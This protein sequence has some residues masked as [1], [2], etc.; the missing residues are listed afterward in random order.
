MTIGEMC[1]QILA[2]D[3]CPQSIK[4]RYPT[5][6]ALFNCSPT[7]ELHDIFTLHRILMQPTITEPTDRPLAVGDM[8]GPLPE[9][10][11]ELWTGLE[12]IK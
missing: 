10:G 8:R 12:W 4:D 7:G 6:E 9:G 11:Y 1:E 3:K 2:S 5:P